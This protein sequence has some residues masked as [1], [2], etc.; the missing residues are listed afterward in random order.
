MEKRQ[1]LWCALYECPYL[2]LRYPIQKPKVSGGKGHKPGFVAIEKPGLMG[3]LGKG[4]AG[5]LAR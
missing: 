1:G 5:F 2:E 3:D 4:A